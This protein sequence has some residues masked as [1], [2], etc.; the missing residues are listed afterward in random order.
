M[1]KTRSYEVG[2]KGSLFHDRL[3]LGAALFQTDIANARVT[4]D[5]NTVE[6]IG[7]TRIRGFEL[8]ANG[9]ILPG[10]TVFGGYTRLDPKVVDGGFTALAVAAVGAQ[11]ATTA[12][13]VSVNT[14]KQVPQT[15]KD[16]FTLWTTVEP[17]KG[18]SIGGGAF[19]S[20]RF[21]GG[22]A[23]N[24]TAS[25]NAAGVITV[26]PATRLLYREVP[27]YWRFDA[28]HRLSRRS[29]LGGQRQCAEFDRQ[30]LFQPGLYQPLRHDRARPFGLRDAELQLL[31]GVENLTRAEIAE[32]LAA[33]PE[34]RAVLIREGAEAGVAEAQAVLGQMLLDG[35]GVARDPRAGFGW[36][37]KA[38]AQGHLM[39][40]NMVG[41][42]YDLGWGT[43]VDKARAAECF[44]I[45]AQRGLEWGMYN[46]ATALALGEGVA[47]DRAAALDWFREAAAMGNAKAMNYVGSFY[48][49]GWVVARD[50]RA[51]ADCMR[52]RP[53]AAI[54]AGPSTMRGCWRRKGAW[55]RRRPGCGAAPRP[56]RR[57]P[58]QGAAPPGGVAL[59][60][61]GAALPC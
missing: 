47:E 18:F 49:D 6:F 8:T 31:M 54:S 45:A 46:Y 13:V 28:P 42:C 23:D 34:E 1:Q 29:A 58:G 38:A 35:T 53:R 40:L 32:R 22:Y 25:Q 48:E 51:A 39:A 33:S 26:A 4:S 5:A 60:E 21:F 55:A 20:S 14:G 19:Y 12:Q 30:G 11:L 27:A 37:L 44:R 7:K 50:M 43:H 9:T 24:R 3:A 16:S 59:A 36:F 2:A 15:A 52:A 56:R 17:V 10:W 41:R 61:L 57:V